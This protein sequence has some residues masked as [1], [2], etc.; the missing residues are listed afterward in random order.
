MLAILM[1]VIKS[2]VCE[3]NSNIAK[4]NWGYYCDDYDDRG[5]NYVDDGA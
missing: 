2:G 5:Y 1:M 3:R 4:A